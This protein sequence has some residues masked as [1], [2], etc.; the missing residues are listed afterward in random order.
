[1]CCHTGFTGP[2]GIVVLLTR[3]HELRGV[4]MVD[5]RGRAQ[6]ESSN[7]PAGVDPFDG[8]LANGPPDPGRISTTL[9]PFA[10]R[11]SSR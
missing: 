5:E 10:E 7:H 2:N 1:M 11:S 9:K 6:P 4:V 8:G 3:I